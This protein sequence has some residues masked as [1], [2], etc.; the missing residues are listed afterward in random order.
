MTFLINTQK[1]LL[2]LKAQGITKLDSN[3]YKDL[4]SM[5]KKYI[6]LLGSVEFNK[7]M[8]NVLFEKLKLDQDP[9]F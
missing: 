8:Q 7:Y 9:S 3:V 1:Y 2:N 5:T 4:N 6:E